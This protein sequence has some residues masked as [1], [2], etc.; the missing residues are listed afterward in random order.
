MLLYHPLSSLWLDRPTERPRSQREP[1]ASSF[2]RHGQC[3]GTEKSIPWASNSRLHCTRRTPRRKG[4][5]AGSC[6]GLPGLRH[7]IPPNLFP[8]LP[9]QPLNVSHASC[10]CKS[11]PADCSN[12]CCSVCPLQSPSAFHHLYVYCTCLIACAYVACGGDMADIIV[13]AN[14]Q[15]KP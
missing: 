2:H 10:A 13:R 7:S 4:M 11:L 12:L 6:V 3:S 14:S 8:C 15:N 9:P 5:W 1:G